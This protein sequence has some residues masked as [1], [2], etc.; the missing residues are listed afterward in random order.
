MCSV[1]ETLFQS[2]VLNWNRLKFP[3]GSNC[4]LS[5]PNIEYS[6]CGGPFQLSYML[7]VCGHILCVRRNAAF[8][9]IVC[10]RDQVGYAVLLS[11]NL[12]GI[13]L[14][15]PCFFVQASMAGRSKLAIYVWHATYIGYNT[16]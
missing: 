16:V 8:A 13:H 7:S 10:R 9:F 1:L 6:E 2:H 11:V 5:I 4:Q 14:R 12:Y 3:C 15:P